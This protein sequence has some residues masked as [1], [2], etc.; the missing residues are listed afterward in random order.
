MDIPKAL[1]DKI[2]R[3]KELAAPIAESRFS[4]E[5]ESVL[6]TALIE[7]AGALQMLVDEAVSTQE[8]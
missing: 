8:D 6:A 2:G 7:L 5:N 3:A 1:I 4:T